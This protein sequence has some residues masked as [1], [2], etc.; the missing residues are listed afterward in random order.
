MKSS[1]KVKNIKNGDGG[2]G[3]TFMRERINYIEGRFFINSEIVVMT[4]PDLNQFHI[5]RSLRST[6]YIYIFH[7]MVSTH[8]Q[9]R[10]GAF[11]H[12]DAIFCVGPHHAREI[13]R[14]EELEHL[15]TKH[16]HKSTFQQLQ[17]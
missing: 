12:Y 15:S 3:M 16:C 10:E 2:M 17:L 9:Y 11:D 5:R 14:R 8:V 7:A 6:H 13:Q 1:G 4:M